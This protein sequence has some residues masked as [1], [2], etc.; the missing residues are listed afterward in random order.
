MNHELNRR[1]FIVAEAGVNHNGD[2]AIAKRLVEVAKEAGADAVK[3]QTFR[4]D[5]LVTRS[6]A[7]A[8]YQV[9][10]TGTDESQAEMLRALE[11]SPDAHRELVAYC[12]A[13][14]IMFMSTPFDLESVDLLA[15]LGMTVWKIASG[16]ITNLPLLRKIGGL[17]HRI[18][19]STGMAT[20]NEV[21]AALNA[22]TTA[23][24]PKDRIT[25]L[26]CHTN[27]PTAMEDVNLRAMLTMRDTLGV[28]V[29]YSDHTPGI[30]VPTAAV[31]LGAS[32]IEKHFTL[33]RS[34]PGPDHKASLEPGELAAM[35]RAIRNIE[36]ALGDGVKR[37]TARE[38]EIAPIGRKSIV[39]TRDI[40]TGEVFS[41]DNL[42]TKRPGSGVS[43]MRWDQVLGQRAKRAFAADE[44]I[45][46]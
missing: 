6:A 20:L 35:V 7:K 21:K 41:T 40:A 42:T 15:E 22:L 43:P 36:R 5:R 10:N 27:Y 31:A 28:R 30:E 34:M 1:V 16:E 8:K 45:E 26:H 29:G 39:A 17:C 24:T 32:V 14:G 38:L 11:L 19:M 2:L 44:L 13:Q 9:E 46:L 3:F 25:V 4:A 12:R 33:D 18:I 23:G 37:P